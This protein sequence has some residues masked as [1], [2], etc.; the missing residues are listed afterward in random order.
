MTPDASPSTEDPGPRRIR[1]IVALTLLEAMRDMDLPVEVLEEENP[2]QTIPRRFGLSE[3]VERQIRQ[4]REDVRKRVR[5]TDEDVRGLFRF[6]IRRPDSAQVF[7]RVGR[8]LAQAEKA[9]SWGRFLPRRVRLARARV[10]TRK[11]LTRLFGRPI[12]G[13][14]R[15]PFVFE[16]RSIFFIEVDPGGDACNLLSGYAAGILEQ[17]SGGVAHV[18]HTSCQGRGDALCRWEGEVL[19]EA[20]TMADREARRAFLADEDAVDAED[21]EVLDH[22]ATG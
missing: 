21:A 13:V 19:R 7:H 12:G 11:A 8:L 4:L 9:P 17:A 1:A 18:R 16:G 2:T 22:G 10:R 15:P 6:V 20:A 5:L 3:V 14:G